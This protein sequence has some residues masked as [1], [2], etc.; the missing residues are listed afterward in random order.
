MKRR[1]RELPVLNFPCEPDVAFRFMSFQL[2]SN[3]CN[4]CLPRT[5]G[6]PG[7]SQDAVLSVPNPGDVLNIREINSINSIEWM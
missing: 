1:R 2:H 4:A 7:W 3:P 5:K 6:V